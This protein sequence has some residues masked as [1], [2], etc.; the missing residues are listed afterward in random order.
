[1]MYQY[2]WSEEFKDIPEDVL[3]R[4]QRDVVYLRYVSGMRFSE[5]AE[6]VE[7]SKQAVLRSHKQALIRIEDFMTALAFLQNCSQ[8]DYQSDILVY[9]EWSHV[10]KEW[11]SPP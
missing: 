1:M 4:N 8:S 6:E 3:T 10:T 9:D 2:D 5:I 11:T 7:R